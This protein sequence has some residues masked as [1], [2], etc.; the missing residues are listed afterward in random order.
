MGN[1][2]LTLDEEKNGYVAKDQLLIFGL[3]LRYSDDL[4]MPGVSDLASAWGHEGTRNNQDSCIVYI[5]A[6]HDFWAIH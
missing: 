2:T 5:A 3:L 4:D 1:H 6:E